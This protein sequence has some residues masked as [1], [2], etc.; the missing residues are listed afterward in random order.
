MK[1]YFTPYRWIADGFEPFKT[2]VT[3]SKTKGRFRTGKIWRHVRYPQNFLIGV[4][5]V[6]QGTNS[7]SEMYYNMDPDSVG[8]VAGSGKIISDQNSSGSKMKLK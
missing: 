8:S 5:Q 1:D 7:V 3:V 4:S 2:R 6:V